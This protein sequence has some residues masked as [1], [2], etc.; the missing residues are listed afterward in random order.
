M[1]LAGCGTSEG[2]RNRHYIQHPARLEIDYWGGNAWPPSTQ[3]T[4]LLNYTTETSSIYDHVFSFSHAWGTLWNHYNNWSWIS[5]IIRAQ[6]RWPDWEIFFERTSKRSRRTKSIFLFYY[7][8]FFFSFF[9]RIH[10]SI[11][12][13]VDN[14][15]RFNAGW[16]SGDFNQ[17]CQVSL[18]C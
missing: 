16:H 13:I 15:L 4:H 18:R 6:W 5:L 11:S 8:M 7:F 1:V 14:D 17:T 10:I 2:L 3:W 9:I 12:G